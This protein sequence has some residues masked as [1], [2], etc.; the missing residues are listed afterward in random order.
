WPRPRFPYRCTEGGREHRN[1]RTF[2]GAKGFVC[3][4]AHGHP[5]GSRSDRVARGTNGLIAHVGKRKSE[6]ARTVSPLQPAETTN[7]FRSFARGTLLPARRRGVSRRER[8][9]RRDGR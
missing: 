3:R 8:L 7:G 5:R 4:F 6:R 2:R 9:A 1:T